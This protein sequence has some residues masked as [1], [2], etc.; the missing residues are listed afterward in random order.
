MEPEEYHRIER[1]EKE[2]WWYQG[3]WSLTREALLRHLPSAPDGPVLDAGCGTGGL[4]SRLGRD[5]S[6]PLTG[7]DLHEPALAA[8]RRRKLSR[9]TRADLARLPFPARTFAAIVSN[10][11]LYHKDVNE[12][13]ALA[14][15][16]RVLM[17][18]G[19]LVMNLPALEALRG[20]HD[21][22]VHTARRYRREQIEERL[23][24]AGILPVRVT[25]RNGFL[26]PAAWL[27]RK[28]HPEEA[29]GEAE[30]DLDLPSPFVNA[31][32]RFILDVENVVLRWTDLPLGMSLHCVARN[33]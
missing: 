30:S 23:Q 31:A 32:L 2:H 1:F 29:G 15:F 3:L 11:V 26:L 17:P 10:D 16:H 27:F 25:Y 21:V 24:A 8:C 14:E 5:L 22:V 18:R 6:R 33:T 13:E 4:L 19:I 12:E 9:V 20:A 28:L 7:V